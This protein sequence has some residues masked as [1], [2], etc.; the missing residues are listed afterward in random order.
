[1]ANIKLP[2][3][4]V[5]GSDTQDGPKHLDQLAAR[6]GLKTKHGRI[7][8]EYALRQVLLLD[9]KQQDYGPGNISA[10]GFPGVVVRMNDKFERL[11]N[12]TKGKR[13]P[14]NESI[15]DTLMDIAN[16]GTI[17]LMVRQN[18]WPSA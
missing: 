12:L 11:K 2:E 10:F 9:N 8:L 17:G 7:A 5:N 16:Y 4:L 15:D 13:R 18:N 3:Q 14:K 6:L 1:M